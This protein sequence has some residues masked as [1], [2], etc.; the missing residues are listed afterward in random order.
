MLLLEAPA[1]PPVPVVS[2]YGLGH[3]NTQAGE[4]DVIVV[5][6][7]CQLIIAAILSV[8]L[9][10]VFVAVILHFVDKSLIVWTF[11]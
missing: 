7:L 6:Y 1:R 4:S 10:E 9:R 3:E 11:Y 5:P 8:K 2:V